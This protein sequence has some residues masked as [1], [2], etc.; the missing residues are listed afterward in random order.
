MHTKQGRAQVPMGEV[1]CRA[2]GY[3]D[4]YDTNGRM[5]MCACS[6]SGRKQRSIWNFHMKRLTHDMH[7]HTLVTP[8][9]ARSFPPPPFYNLFIPQI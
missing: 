1:K 3:D 5:G 4:T 9:S 7:M 8:K 6:C 2:V